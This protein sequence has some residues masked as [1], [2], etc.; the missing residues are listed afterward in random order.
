MKKEEDKIINILNETTDVNLDK[1]YHNTLAKI[2]EDSR[3][4]EK[5]PIKLKR[6][7]KISFLA[8]IAVFFFCIPFIAVMISTTGFKKDYSM[9]DEEKEQTGDSSYNAIS[10]ESM[11]NIKNSIYSHYILENVD[12][13]I[14]YLYVNNLSKAE[15]ERLFQEYNITTN[16]IE[17]INTYT[18]VIGKQDGIEKIAY[19]NGYEYVVLE[20]KATYLVYDIYINIQSQAK[21]DIESISL[22]LEN[23][24]IVYYYNNQDIVYKYTK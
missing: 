7:L 4:Y 11:S 21:S 5:S 15:L 12:F 22:Y 20:S 6:G 17:D 8:L 16:L 18:V 14:T 3:V 9:K 2:R 1:V 24:H 10:N 23:D 13:D 19:T